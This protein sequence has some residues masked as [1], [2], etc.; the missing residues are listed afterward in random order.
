MSLLG[1]SWTYSCVKEHQFILNH[2]QCLAF[3]LCS[4]MLRY[5]RNLNSSL[6]ALAGSPSSLSH[7]FHLPLHHLHQFLPHPPHGTFIQLGIVLVLGLGIT[8]HVCEAGAVVQVTEEIGFEVKYFQVD[9]HLIGHALGET[10]FL[11]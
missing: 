8:E 11:A 6:S 9:I 5:H 10:G 7:T 4:R 3:I 1:C 2:D